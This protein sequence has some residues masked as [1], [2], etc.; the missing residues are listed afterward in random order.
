MFVSYRRGTNDALIGW[1]V[2]R[3]SAAFGS[4]HVFRDTSDIK[5]ADDWLRAIEAEL[6]VADV[7]VVA[8]G[9]NWLD[10]A[11]RIRTGCAT[12]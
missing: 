3:L 9:A 7:L 8:I 1:F 10:I 12:R 4:D 2:D 6:A 5:G 11:D